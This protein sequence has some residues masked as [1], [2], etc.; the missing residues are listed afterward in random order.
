MSL[1][2]KQLEKTKF[3]KYKKLTKVEDGF[4]EDSYY[5]YLI[6]RDGLYELYKT[7]Y[8][9]SSNITKEFWYENVNDVKRMKRIERTKYDCDNKII[10]VKEQV[11]NYSKGLLCSIDYCDYYSA[12]DK[13]ELFK[14]YTELF[15]VKGEQVYMYGMH[16]GPADVDASVGL[17]GMLSVEELKTLPIKTM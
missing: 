3:P 7:N 2:L 10:F 9:N 8:V 16:K 4:Y 11:F 17:D 6:S 15:I 12:D 14:R 5:Q 1:I 13:L